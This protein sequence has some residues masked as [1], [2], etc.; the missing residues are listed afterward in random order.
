MFSGTSSSPLAQVKLAPAAPTERCR[1]SLLG[2][3]DAGADASEAGKGPGGL[4]AEL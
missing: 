3:E 1:C 4:G 2:S